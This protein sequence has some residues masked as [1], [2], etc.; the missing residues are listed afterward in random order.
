MKLKM[1]HVEAVQQLGIAGGY[2]LDFVQSYLPGFQ[3]SDDEETKMY[4]APGWAIHVLMYEY[5]DNA[6][7]MKAQRYLNRFLTE[8]AEKV[9][10]DTKEMVVVP[11]PSYL[12]NGEVDKKTKPQYVIGKQLSTL[13]SAK[14][15]EECLVKNSTTQAKYAGFKD[16]HSGAFVQT[17]HF[18][19]PTDVLLVDDVYGKGMTLRAC[20]KE[21]RKDP[22]VRNVYFFSI[23]R[24]H[25]DGLRNAPA[26][27]A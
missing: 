4:S 8:F 6:K 21:L 5:D 1:A 22:M 18:E 24:T 15:Y 11:I 23:G 13:L 10:W 16:W 27:A 9:D 2:T 7:V 26:Q 25:K 17:K 14:A 12:D 19:E 20:L 3:T